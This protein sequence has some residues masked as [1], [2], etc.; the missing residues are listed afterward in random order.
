MIFPTC[1]S[2]LSLSRTLTTDSQ[3]TFKQQQYP[4]NSPQ[5]PESQCYTGRNR[6][7]IADKQDPPL[8]FSVTKNAS[9][10]PVTKLWPYSYSKRIFYRMK[11]ISACN[12]SADICRSILGMCMQHTLEWLSLRYL[13]LHEVQVPASLHLC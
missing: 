10:T 2:S 13:L 11:L 9:A 6:N 1:F 5:K 3:Q 4:H 8:K 12:C 7:I